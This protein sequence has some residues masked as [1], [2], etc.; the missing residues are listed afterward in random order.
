MAKKVQV[1]YVDDLDNSVAADETVAFGLDGK[2][3]TIDLSAAHA[4]QL[5]DAL[6]I[7]VA[8]GEVVGRA[9]RAGRRSA[10]SAGPSAGEI[11][12]WAKSQGLEV[13]ERGRISAEVRAA[14][15]AAH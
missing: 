15:E 6:A 3:Y 7:Y 12:D 14:Y 10:R 8:H 13:S 1:V 2:S 9:S 5:R 4:A 11:R